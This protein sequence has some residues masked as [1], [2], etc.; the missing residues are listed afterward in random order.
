MPWCMLQWTLSS[1]RSSNNPSLHNIRTLYS[2]FIRHCKGKFQGQLIQQVDEAYLM[3]VLDL[4]DQSVTHWSTSEARLV[5]LVSVCLINR[6]TTT[7][8]LSWIVG[9]Q[10]FRAGLL[11]I[12]SAAI[13]RNLYPPHIITQQVD[14]SINICIQFLA[15]LATSFT[16]FSA[17]GV[18]LLQIS[19]STACQNAVSEDLI[20]SLRTSQEQRAVRRTMQFLH[21]KNVVESRE[22]TGSQHS[23]KFLNV[24]SYMSTEEQKLKDTIFV[25]T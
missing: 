18:T 3:A 1:L 17:Y 24:L 25:S 22:N 20:Q 15:R 23:S 7:N 8:A 5:F 21:G 16:A 9:L 6:L 10:N 11:C 19:R 12:S 2:W 13:L 14:Q 4:S